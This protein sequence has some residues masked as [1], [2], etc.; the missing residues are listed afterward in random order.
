MR[1]D[2][3]FPYSIVKSNV[4]FSTFLNHKGP[5]LFFG[6]FYS[7]SIDCYYTEYFFV[8]LVFFFTHSL[9][10][11][12]SLHAKTF[13]EA[14]YTLSV[15]CWIFFRVISYCKMLNQFLALSCLTILHCLILDS[16]CCS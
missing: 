11:Y 2:N 5:L 16:M 9:I 13:L 14:K 4:S 12:I 10:C 8:S 6:S 7:E 15:I 1:Q 3:F